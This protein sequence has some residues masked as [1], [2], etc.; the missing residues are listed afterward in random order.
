[1]LVEVKMKGT[2]KTFLFNWNKWAGQGGTQQLVASSPLPDHSKAIEFTAKRGY[3]SRAGWLPV[4]LN[5][6]SR[7]HDTDKATGMTDG[8]QKRFFF[9]Q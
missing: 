4:A 9:T 2:D 3:K 8:K 6:R 7:F 1:M 5:V